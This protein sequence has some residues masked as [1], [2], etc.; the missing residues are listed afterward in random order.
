MTIM[1]NQLTNEETV[2]SSLLSKISEGK[3]GDLSIN[4]KRS[5]ITQND[6]KIDHL[7]LSPEVVS[8]LERDPVEFTCTLN[9]MFPI[10]DANLRV[11]WSLNNYKIKSLEHSRLQTSVSKH[12]HQ[13]QSTLHFRLTRLKDTGMVKC[14]VESG[15]EVFS[16]TGHLR[17]LVKPTVLLVPAML[18]VKKYE[19][20][21]LSCHIYNIP[22]HIRVEVTWCKDGIIFSPF[23]DAEQV[24]RFP[25][26]EELHL[27]SLT[28]NHVYSCGLHR[29]TD[30]CATTSMV[31]VTEREPVPCKP[32]TDEKGMFW[33]TTAVGDMAVVPCPPGT[34]GMVTR[35]C[36]DGPRGIGIWKPASYRHCMKETF[37]KL[38][39][40][41]QDLKDGLD[42]E[43]VTMI[44]EEFS[45]V[46]E[47]L[48]EDSNMG[49][50]MASTHMLVDISDITAERADEVT[51]RQSELFVDVVSKILDDD[52][53]ENWKQMYEE[54]GESASMVMSSLTTF[55]KTISRTLPENQSLVIEKE[56]LVLKVSKQPVDNVVFPKQV[57]KNKTRNVSTFLFISKLAL[58]KEFGDEIVEISTV[59]YKSL[60]KILPDVELD[61]TNVATEINTQVLSIDF[62]SKPKLSLDPPIEFTFEHI[63]ERVERMLGKVVIDSMIHHQVFIPRRTATSLT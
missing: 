59:L 23:S 17:V 22:E 2:Y 52:T 43:S 37:L 14:A 39:R 29:F 24:R 21:V 30:P 33:N 53:S 35:K 36:Q 47:S 12:L 8:V 20:G 26:H 5:V 48:P 19:D 34:I 54:T 50:I 27:T 40:K 62:P 18:V 28:S 31:R 49:D 11:T 16:A 58:Q 9:G 3:I 60:A 51:E 32:D 38:A 45:N 10:P 41:I 42:V 4:S 25:D 46:T 13:W 7:S 56:N 6:H 15:G 61:K 55:S 57:T 1:M 44:L 63:A